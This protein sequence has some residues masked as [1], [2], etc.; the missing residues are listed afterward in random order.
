MNIKLSVVLLAALLPVACGEISSL[1]E[2]VSALEKAAAVSSDDQAS[3]QLYL[4]DMVDSAAEE[5]TTAS[6]AP[7]S[8]EVDD[9]VKDDIKTERLAQMVAKLMTEL[10][11]DKSG[12]LSLEE[13]LVGPAK[14]A[15]DKQIDEEKLAK[16]TGRLTEDFKKYAGADVLLTAD[17]LKTLL[18][19]SAPR[20][21]RHRHDHFPGK[22]EERVKLAWADVIAKYDTNADGTLNQ[23]EYEAMEADKVAAF[24]K[25]K[26]DR[27]DHR[28][29]GRPGDDSRK[30]PG[31]E[32]DDDGAGEGEVQG[33]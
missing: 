22:H 30:G 8:P 31:S 32:S 25:I 26:D 2:G 23:A 27:A 28:H 1:E 5:T 29:G 19:E 20:I 14:R 17:E 12:N 24:K 18:S 10:D 9:S 13:F 16:I 21:G 3:N 11:A 7:A 15:E 4:D 6:P 33:E